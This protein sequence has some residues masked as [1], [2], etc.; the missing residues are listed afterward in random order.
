MSLQLQAANEEIVAWTKTLEERVDQKT[1]ELKKA[2][3]HM[4][5]VEKMA[6]VGKMAAVVAHEINNPLAG[7]LTYAKL[8]RKW[9][10]RGQ[11][12]KRDEALQCLD[13]IAGESRRCGDLVK[14]LLSFS[15]TAPMHVQPV[16][17]NQLVD[18]TVRL[19]MHQLE[20]GNIQLQLDLAEALPSVSCD[21]AQIEQVFLA[22]I[23]NAIEAMA[24]GGNLWLRT[25]A[26]DQQVEIQVRDDGS[27]IPEDVLPQIF[28]PFLTTKESGHGVG[29]GLAISR[30]IIERH[31][32]Q[33]AVQSEF[34]KG[35][36]FIITLPQQAAAAAVN[37]ESKAA[38]ST[39]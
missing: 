27:G 10:D 16:D 4:L 1:L 9:L 36:T 2:H 38:I 29:L 5:H 22:L 26:T 18:R 3:D 20:M 8:L 30:G 19:V 15:R 6:S 21:A 33:I 32:G 14:N 25:R 13:L 23:M 11:V 7:I 17:L 31:H 39:R 37:D 12:E 24:R 35:T 28:E 34:G